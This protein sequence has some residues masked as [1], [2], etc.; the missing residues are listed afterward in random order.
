MD[1]ERKRCGGSDGQINGFRRSL[2]SLSFTSQ[3]IL[4]RRS[5]TSH[6]TANN[7]RSCPFQRSSSLRKNTFLFRP[8]AGLTNEAFSTKRTKAASTGGSTTFALP[9]NE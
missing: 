4:N 3:D 9:L 5:N 2:C 1:I 6:L 7:E 8:S